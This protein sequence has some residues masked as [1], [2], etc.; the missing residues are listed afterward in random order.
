MGSVG[1][2]C[3]VSKNREKTR[4]LTGVLVQSV[5]IS[6]ENPD[7]LAF[8]NFSGDSHEKCVIFS[9]FAVLLPEFGHLGHFDCFES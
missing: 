4:T 1:G 7:F 8:Y 2:E 6:K 3:F 5:A 9:A